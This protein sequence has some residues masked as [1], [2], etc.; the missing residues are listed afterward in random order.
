MP[1]DEPPARRINDRFDAKSGSERQ[2]E[3][4]LEEC[5]KNGSD[6]RRLLSEKSRVS[7][8]NLCFQP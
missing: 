5:R 2:N 4:R 6:A 1:H 8:P 3:H 7:A